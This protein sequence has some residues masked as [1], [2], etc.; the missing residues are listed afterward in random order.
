[1]EEAAASSQLDLAAAGAWSFRCIWPWSSW[2]FWRSSCHFIFGIY[3]GIISFKKSNRQV[4]GASD[5]P[6][7][8]VRYSI[9]QFVQQ[10]AL[11]GEDNPSCLDKHLVSEAHWLKEA[12]TS[13]YDFWL[14]KTAADKDL[15]FRRWS[16]ERYFQ[17]TLLVRL[18]LNRPKL[19]VFCCCCC[20]LVRT[21][22]TNSHLSSLSHFLYFLW[23]LPNPTF[24]NKDGHLMWSGGA[25]DY[26][27][28]AETSHFFLP[29]SFPQ[30]KF[31]STKGSSN[32][33]TI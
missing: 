25:R 17:T 31:T 12:A 20:F 1:M 7:V 29:P 2:D 33:N 18:S 10:Y 16:T 13:P 8:S 14:R 9:S 11:P 28:A 4:W 15:E 30:V 6:C 3:H 24:W 23:V 5:L 19:R 32:N 21:T 26:W 22:K 27:G